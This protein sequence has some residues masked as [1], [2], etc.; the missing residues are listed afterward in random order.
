MN[1]ERSYN[2]L[3]GKKIKE[4]W[5]SLIYLMSTGN[6]TCAFSLMVP[7]ELTHYNRL[8]CSRRKWAKMELN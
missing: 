7:L 2:Q 6:S 1:K 8:D 5:F 3:N 4:N